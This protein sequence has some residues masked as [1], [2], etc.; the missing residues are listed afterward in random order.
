MRTTGSEMRGVAGQYAMGSQKVAGTW[1]EVQK[2]R[3][4]EAATAAAIGPVDGAGDDCVEA[5]KEGMF[6]AD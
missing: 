2:K 5:E 1:P 6:D 4:R 3:R